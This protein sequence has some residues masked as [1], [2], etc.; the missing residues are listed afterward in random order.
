[1]D[2][3]AERIELAKVP[4]RNLDLIS[5]DELEQLL[6]A[7]DGDDIKSLRDKAILELLFSTGLR[8]SELCALNRDTFS[9]AKSGEI[10]IRGKGGKIRV[11]FIS[12]SARQAVKN[13]L[14]KRTR[15]M[16][17]FTQLEASLPSWVGIFAPNSAFRGRT[18]ALRCQSRHFQKSYPTYYSPLFR[19]RP[20]FKRRR[21]A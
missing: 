2:V 10:S 9:E 14:D 16:T 18:E 11:V 15:W 1:M 4:D 7:P 6:K 17:L 20:S 13:Y 8:V 12:E 5:S 21:F 19:H 3:P